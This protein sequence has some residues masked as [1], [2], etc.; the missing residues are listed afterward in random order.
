MIEN[1]SGT[2]LSVRSRLIDHSLFRLFAAFNAYFALVQF[3]GAMLTTE[4]SA[5]AIARHEGHPD[6]ISGFASITLTSAAGFGHRYISMTGRISTP[7][8]YQDRHQGR[9]ALRLSGQL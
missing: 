3:R 9:E 2:F 1:T 4:I 7:T 5:A 6:S 8:S